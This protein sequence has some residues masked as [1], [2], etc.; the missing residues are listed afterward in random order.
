M[1]YSLLFT[2]RASGSRF[3]GM[4]P[5]GGGKSS[6]PSG[7][8]LLRQTVAWGCVAECLTSVCC[9]LVLYGE[10][11]VTSTLLNVVG[12]L[13]AGM[14]QAVEEAAD[15]PLLRQQCSCFQS[16]FI[17]V[18]TSFA[19]TTE[20]AA[21]LSASR[22]HGPLRGIAYVVT[23][24]ATSCACFAASH[25]AAAIALSNRRGG[26]MR[27]PPTPKPPRLLRGLWGVVGLVWLYV[28]LTPAGSV[29]EP[30]EIAEEGAPEL[31]LD[32]RTLPSKV[33]PPA[34]SPAARPCRLLRH[35]PHN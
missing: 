26:C 12:P 35:A 34:R 32:S 24:L 21:R 28:L 11:N 13:V 14:M 16:G 1:R 33:S 8:T 7:S 29:F 9:P 23:S 19:F 27:V 25:A 20:Q 6:S 2:V 18:F 22:T 15:D 10:V 31:S 5:L 17:S 3:G 4:L 30:L